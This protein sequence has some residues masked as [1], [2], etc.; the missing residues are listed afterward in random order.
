MRRTTLAVFLVTLAVA[1]CAPAA[2]E[3]AFP[4]TTPASLIVLPDAAA[5]PVAAVPVPPPLPPPPTAQGALVCRF[6]PLDVDVAGLSLVPGGP[7]FA[8][9]AGGGKTRLELL[10]SGDWQGAR[11]D[12]EAFGVTVR[13]IADAEAIYLHFRRPTLIA[14]ILVPYAYTHVAWKAAPAGRIAVTVPSL[15]HEGDRLR[16]D[17][18]AALV[19]HPCSDLT[20]GN[21]EYEVEA[22]FGPMPKK[23][24]ARLLPNRRVAVS[25]APSG[26]TAAEVS[27]D[28]DSLFIDVLE[29]RGPSSRIEIDLGDALL[30]GWVASRNVAPRPKEEG[31]MGGILG[32]LGGS[33]DDLTRGGKRTACDREVPL[34]ASVDGESRT[35]GA[36]HKGTAFFVLERRGELARIALDGRPPSIADMVGD[37]PGD[38]GAPPAL[39]GAIVLRDPKAALLVRSADLSGCAKPH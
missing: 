28:N 35:V 10:D 26:P 2:D 38:A 19:E 18:I 22:A 32:A 7:P 13:G 25:T 33:G 11:V 27:V 21:A 24:P 23:R 12:V 8:S 36:I 30:V 29:T 20:P 15:G 1:A 6:D 39:A 3:G 37:G 31:G 14:G 5:A 16:S 9:I 34:V 4:A 17:A